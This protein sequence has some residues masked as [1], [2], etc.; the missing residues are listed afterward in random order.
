MKKTNLIAAGIVIVLAILMGVALL[1]NQ[2]GMLANKTTF[3][4][5]ELNVTVD[6]EVVGTLT[7]DE[8]IALGGVEYE[9]IY[10]TSKTDPV[11]ESYKGVELKK[12]F[13]HF[14]V[15]LQ[16]KSAVTATAVDNFAMAYSVDEVMTDDSLYVTYE[17]NGETI[18]GAEDDDGGPLMVIVKNDQFSNRRCKWL[19][20]V[21]VES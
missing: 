19:I 6:G 14:N 21:G 10:D 8:L 9:A 17:R 1:L 16:G 7:Y 20:S 4:N 11:M 12:V 13:E 15:D 2:E 5:V 3:E 18:L